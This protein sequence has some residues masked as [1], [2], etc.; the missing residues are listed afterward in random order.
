MHREIEIEIRA[1]SGFY[2]IFKFLAP[3]TW[4]CANEVGFHG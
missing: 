4:V 2:T 3:P 1:S